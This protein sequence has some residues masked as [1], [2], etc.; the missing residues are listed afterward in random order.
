MHRAV[1]TNKKH[2]YVQKYCNISVLS[3]NVLSYNLSY[4]YVFLFD[5]AGDVSNFENTERNMSQ[6]R[7]LHTLTA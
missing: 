5:C 3:V 4:L 6:F 1:R 2:S 7:L